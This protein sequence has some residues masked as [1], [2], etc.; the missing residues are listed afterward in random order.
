MKKNI[1]KFDQT[2][3]IIAGL[4]VIALGIICQNWWGLLGLV[5]I[6]TGFVKFCPLYIPFKISTV[7]KESAPKQ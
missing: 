4:V 1:G 7:K 3:R 5:F 6:F 2:L